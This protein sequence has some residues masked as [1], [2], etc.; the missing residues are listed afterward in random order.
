MAFRGKSKS[1]TQAR[2]MPPSAGRSPSA[3]RATR[4]GTVAS[5]ACATVA[6]GAM[7]LSMGFAGAAAGNRSGLA[8]PSGA[9]L[10]TDTPAAATAFATWRGRPLDVVEAWSDRSTWSDIDNPT[11]LYQ[12]WS[13][14]PSTMAF[15][16]AMLPSDVSGVS[17]QACANGSYNTYWKKFGSVISSYGLGTSIIRLGWEFNGNWYIWKASQPATW[18]KCWQ[19]IVTSARATAPKLRWDWNVNRGQATGLADPTQAYPGNAYVDIVGVD[20]YDNWPAAN[21]PSGWQAQLNGTQGLA[22]WLAFATAHGKLFSVPEW[23]NVS[24]G[25]SAGGDD[26]GYVTDML[27]FFRAHAVQMA[28]EANFQGAA[29]DSTGGSY[30]AGTTTP[31]SA[32]VYRAGF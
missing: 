22:Y 2:G 21:S 3:C 26:P 31:K 18:V 1:S 19:Q 14:T 9:Y 8:W 25:A 28:Y 30:A 32:A 17:L 27:A 7:V 12:R 23:G 10:P 4:L 20:S 13:G 5:A 15:G 11:W 24:T 29:S 6:G 16:V